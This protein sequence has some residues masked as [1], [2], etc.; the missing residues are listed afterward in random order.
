[1]ATVSDAT[2]NQKHETEATAD[3]MP[4]ANPMKR[5]DHFSISGDDSALPDEE[6][7]VLARARALIPL[8]AERAPTASGV[9]HGQPVAHGGAGLL[10]YRL[11]LTRGR[12][13]TV[14]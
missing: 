7:T 13:R 9:E 4:G 8:L 3:R 14:L 1:V 12:R 2:L 11:C 5:R 10:R 6:R